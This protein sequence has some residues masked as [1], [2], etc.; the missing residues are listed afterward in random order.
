[1]AAQKGKVESLDL[2]AFSWQGFSLRVPSGWDMVSF[3]GDRSGGRVG[4]ADEH[5]LRLEMEWETARGGSEPAEIASRLLQQ[6]RKRAKKDKVEISVR[7]D[8]KL[9]SF[10]DRET[11]CYEWSAQNQGVGMVTR[12]GECRHLVHVIITAPLD[13]RP[14]PLAR[15]IFASLKDHPEG[16]QELWRFYD[17]EF[18]C[19]RDMVPKR[20]ELKAGRVRM[21]FQKRGR[22]LEFVRVS[23]AQ[24]LLSDKTLIGWFK[25]FYRESLRR[26]DYSVSDARINGHEALRVE[27]HR[28]L[29]VNPA[30]LIGRD[31]RLRVACWHCEPTNRLMIVRHVGRV[32]LE[33]EF[34]RALESMNCCPES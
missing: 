7:R 10:K 9:A 1:M 12:C 20:K 32:G 13:D 26:W 8:T 24:V 19:P 25:E 6:L 31:R 30:R 5:A 29:L 23:L 22:Q 11:H 17:M 4:L 21:E 16:D 28:K 2:K 15:R 34:E 33:N 3:R 27:G 14:H 18:S